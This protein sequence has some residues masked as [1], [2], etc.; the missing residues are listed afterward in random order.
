MMNANWRSML[1]GARTKPSMF[2][3]SIESAHLRPLHKLVQAVFSF[4]ALQEPMSLTIRVSPTQY[5]AVGRSGPLTKTLE[6]YMDPNGDV[7]Y[8]EVSHAGSRLRSYFE[9]QNPEE[10]RRRYQGPTF[11]SHEGMYA[12]AFYLAARGA[13]AVRTSSGLWCQTYRHGWPCTEPFV[14]EDRPAIG[15]LVAAALSPEWF[16]GLPFTP[17]DLKA[18]ELQ[19]PDVTVEWHDTDDLVPACPSRECFFEPENVRRW[20][21]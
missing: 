7:L 9:K 20:L 5:H 11:H 14:V 21:A 12:D 15:L 18:P 6:T 3:G 13:L 10:W 1:K 17:E 2:V 8:D 4:G 16:T 19:Q